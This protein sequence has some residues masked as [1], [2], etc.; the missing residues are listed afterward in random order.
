[1]S[2]NMYYSGSSRSKFLIPKL[3]HSNRD[4]RQIKSVLEHLR[5]AGRCSARTRG[6]MS[7]RDGLRYPGTIMQLL[8]KEPKTQNI[9]RPREHVQYPPRGKNADERMR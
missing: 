6:G 7:T 8:R 5:N 9:L 4:V 3:A 2:M 1:M